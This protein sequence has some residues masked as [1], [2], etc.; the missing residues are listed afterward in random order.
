MTKTQKDLAKARPSL[1]KVA[2]LTATICWIFAAINVFVAYSLWFAY[3]PTV[4]LFLVNNFFNFQVWAIAFLVLAFI[5]TYNLLKNHWNGVRKT[6]L[7]GIIVKVAWE[8]TLILRIFQ[9]KNTILLAV[10][11][12]FFALVQV[13]TYIFFLPE[14]TEGRD[15]EQQQ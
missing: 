7:A 5:G 1:F 9:N 2:P 10:L 13:A 6:L 15:N 12:G 11:W 8:I 14:I 3:R 4:K